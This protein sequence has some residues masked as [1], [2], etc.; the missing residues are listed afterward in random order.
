MYL[1]AQYAV[2]EA[3]DPVNGSAQ[4]SGHHPSQ[5]HKPILMSPQGS[6][7]GKFGCNQFA[8]YKAAYAWHVTFSCRF[9]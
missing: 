6:R 9:L 8:C 1:L 2:L 7:C 4:I 3:N 5:T